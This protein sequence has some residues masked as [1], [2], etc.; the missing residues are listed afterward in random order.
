M[1]WQP[2][3]TTIRNPIEDKNKTRTIYSAVSCISDEDTAKARSENV[4]QAKVLASSRRP[5]RGARNSV[6][7]F[8]V[9]SVGKRRS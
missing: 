3:L 4:D 5:A 6:I 1:G 2:V 8:K 9:D 7:F